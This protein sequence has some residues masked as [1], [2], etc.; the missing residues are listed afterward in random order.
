MLAAQKL[1]DAQ[2]LAEEPAT[3]RRNATIRK[4]NEALLETQLSMIF[5]I[6]LQSATK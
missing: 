1:R 3:E 2:A 5:A 4:I 6:E